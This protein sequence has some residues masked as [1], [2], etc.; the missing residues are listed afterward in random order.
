MQFV[1]IRPITSIVNFVVL[2][3]SQPS[4]TTDG[5]DSADGGYLTFFASPQFAIAMINNVSVFFAFM[6]L[7]KFYHA[8]RDEL[9]WCK[10]LAKFLCIKAVVFLTFWQGLAVAIAVASTGDPWE[11]N[12]NENDARDRATSIQNVLICLE[13]LIFS[14]AHWCTFPPEEWEE[15]FRPRVYA[16]PGFAFKDFAEDV[17]V[18]F[19]SRRANRERRRNP[20]YVATDIEKEERQDDCLAHEEPQDDRLGN[21]DLK[22]GDL[23]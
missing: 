5:G 8:V 16:K 6:G 12:S 17:S 22:L 23:A 18:V 15:D 11:T 20:Q 13:M 14:I 2:T 19:H 1:F 7:L 10:P 3:L 9:L 4:A 21:E